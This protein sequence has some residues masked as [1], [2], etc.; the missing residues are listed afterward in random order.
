MRHCANIEN[1]FRNNYKRF[2]IS[3]IEEGK[4]TAN[5]EFYWG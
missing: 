3:G 1:N 5:T 4:E 2:V